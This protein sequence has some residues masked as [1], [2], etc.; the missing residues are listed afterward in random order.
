MTQ[1]E[2]TPQDYLTLLRRWRALI[3]ICAV[4]GSV[5]AYG[6]SRFLPNR[7]RSQSTVL[8]EQPIVPSDFVRQVG[9]N[10]VNE[11]LATMKQEI[12]SRTQL[13]P[14]I[15]QF[16]LYSEDVN[17]VPIDELVGRLQLAIGVTPIMPLA[18]S[19][20]FKM[21]GFSV[22]VVW[23]NPRTAQELCAAI[24]SMFIQEDIRQRQGM[25]EETTRF[26]AQ[27]LTEAKAKLDEQDAKLAD[28]E[29]HH[30]GSL[31]DEVQT[32]LGYLSGLYAQLD[33]ATQ[34]LT[35]AQLDK[36]LATATLQQQIAARQA[37]RTGNNP[38]TFGDELAQLQTQLA[39]LQAKYTDD[40][41]DVVKTKIQIEAVKK[42]IAESDEANKLAQSD[43]TNTKGPIEP[44]QFIQL[45]AQ[46][47]TDD[48]IIA[49][50]TKQEERIQEQ[51][52]TAQARI[53]Q[54]PGI[55][56]QYKALTRDYQTALEFYKDLLNKQ[57]QSAMS[58]ELV[59]RQQGQ[60][61]QLL[62]P[63]TLPDKPFFPNRMQFSLG[64]LGG[65]LAL[66]LGLAFLL[67]MRDTSLRTERD[68]ETSL[69]LPVLAMVPAIGHLSGKKRKPAVS[70]LMANSDLGVGA[71]A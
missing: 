34:A 61:F 6:V 2:W 58:T 23:D 46:I 42:K 32:N 64:G 62:D 1:R 48:Q 11:R 66:G 36:S 30:F 28:F 55:E 70:R 69:Q 53:Q 52:K 3:L 43:A 56:Q 12:L 44:V 18:E 29:A 68:V 60:Q 71:G 47:R 59:R 20:S 16:G 8:V 5:I 24:T 45:R 26:L 27:Q 39:T 9:S 31:P 41:P 10:D 40:Y 14:L 67:E 17:H 13:E 25:S 54:T 65:G 4:L 51:I 7:Y 38:E 15:R 22:T 37:S 49:D 50:K 35:R 57:A 63:A 33:A 21:P 19:G